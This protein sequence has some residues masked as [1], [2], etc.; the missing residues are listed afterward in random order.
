MKQEFEMTREEMDDILQ[1]NKDQMPVMLIG[2][3]TTGM[4]L[5]EKINRYWS[6]LGDKYGFDD[7]TVEPSAKGELFFLAIPKPIIPP[8][9]KEEIAME[10]YD[11]ISKI[12]D[13]LEKDDFQ[14][15][16]GYLVNCIPFLAL[17]KMAFK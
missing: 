6:G 5:R 7:A 1:I 3:I 11:S 16:G 9:T 17:K 15:T 8:K 10:K 2:G 13:A 12:V 14:S 4:D